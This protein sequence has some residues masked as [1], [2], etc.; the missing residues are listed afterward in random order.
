MIF[1]VY[2]CI[3]LTSSFPHLSYKSFFL[4]CSASRGVDAIRL[5]SSV[6]LFVWPVDT[7]LLEKSCTDGLGWWRRQLWG[8][9]RD[10]ETGPCQSVS[11]RGTKHTF[12][13]QLGLRLKAAGL[14]FIMP[15]VMASE[16]NI[17]GSFT[18]RADET[19]AR[20]WHLER[21]PRW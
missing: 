12:L 13:V 1:Y 15:C 9:I 19:G 2:M 14:C 18:V 20:A 21:R 17:S 5:A 7:G 8:S 4:F 10:L 16:W 11:A 3:V 6:Y